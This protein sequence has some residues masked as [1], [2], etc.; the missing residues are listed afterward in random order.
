[1][2]TRINRYKGNI[3]KIFKDFKYKS[4]HIPRMFLRSGALSMTRF[5]FPTRFFFLSHC[6]WENNAYSSKT[7]KDNFTKF[8]MQLYWSIPHIF[9]LMTFDIRGHIWPLRPKQKF[10]N[11]QSSIRGRTMHTI[12]KLIKITLQNFIC[13]SIG[14]FPTHFI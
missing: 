10:Q 3:N 13:N 2:K 7:I 1:M 12:Q 6:A 8:Y 11:H 5:F 14:Q 4:P 9:C